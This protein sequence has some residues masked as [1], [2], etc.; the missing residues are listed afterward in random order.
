MRL[1]EDCHAADARQPD[2]RPVGDVLQSLRRKVLMGVTLLYCLQNAEQ[3]AGTATL[4]G[5]KGNRR[6]MGMQAW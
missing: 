5:G 3:F 1:V 4:L 2:V 6:I